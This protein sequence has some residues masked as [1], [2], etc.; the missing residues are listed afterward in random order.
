MRNLTESLSGEAAFLTGED[1]PEL[2]RE[3]L[4][5][6]MKFY[7]TLLQQESNNPQ[8]HLTTGK[9]FILNAHIFLML[10]ADTL[11]MHNDPQ[12]A[13]LRRR[14][15]NHYLRG[16]DHVLRG[17]EILYP[18][19]T[20]SIR[21]GC[22]DSALSQVSI[23]DTSYLYW[24]SVAWLGAIRADRR[25]LALG[26]SVRRPAALLHKTIS[27]K[28]D[29]GEGAAHEAL[30]LYLSSAPTSLGGDMDKAKEHFQK[31]LSYSSG[32][33]ASTFVSGAL[34]FAVKEND[35]QSFRELLTQATRIN[36]YEDQ[37][38]VFM[39]TVYR[40][41]ARWLLDKKNH[42]FSSED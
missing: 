35:K 10:P 17:L 26:L 41:H 3:A 39:N 5:F 13:I 38:T 23:S 16:R 20:D 12:A 6:T 27:L 7:E 24:S 37:S 2:I 15:K 32:K 42:F 11:Q 9:L 14:A 1:D 34:N 25:D 30:S 4:P 22:I 21:T 28:S 19:I 8:L 29:F 40:N 18:G 33:N 31:A 36:P